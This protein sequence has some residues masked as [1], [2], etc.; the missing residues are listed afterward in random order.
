MPFVKDDPR[1]NRKGR[2]PK[3]RAFTELLAK[4][5]KRDGRDKAFVDILWTLATQGQVTLAGRVIRIQDAGDI[6]ALAKMLYSQ[7]DGPP[8]QSIE[9]GG[10]DGGDIPVTWVDRSVDYRSGLNG[11]TDED[12]E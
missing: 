5:G 12:G 4:A 8:K 7:I 3:G 2:P 11:I 10:S 6:I 1:I 9:V